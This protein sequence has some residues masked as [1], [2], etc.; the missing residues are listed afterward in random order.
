M[1]REAP[2]VLTCLISGW[3]SRGV[4]P[5]IPARSGRGTLGEL[6]SD[7]LASQEWSVTVPCAVCAGLVHLKVSIPSVCQ[8]VV[9]SELSASSLFSWKQVM[10]CYHVGCG[11]RPQHPWGHEAWRQV[12]IVH[13]VSGR[14]VTWEEVWWTHF[15]LLEADLC[16]S[17]HFAAGQKGQRSWI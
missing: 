9:S 14:L 10:P 3:K 15:W 12:C 1:L 5:R 8:A 7:S 4:L 17:Q 16:L 6:P 2:S 13:F 11:E